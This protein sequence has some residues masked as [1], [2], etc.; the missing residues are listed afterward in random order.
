MNDTLHRQWHMLR[1]LPRAPRKIA[2]AQIEASLC[3][4]GYEID[5]RSIQRDLVNLSAMF[6]IECDNRSRPYGW[7]WSREASPFDLPCMDVHAALAFR[8]AAE[9]LEHLLPASTRSHLE[10]YFRQACTILAQVKGALADWPENVRAINTGPK[11]LPPVVDAVLLETVHHALMEQRR[12]TVEYTR[13]GHDTPRTYDLSPLGLVYRDSVA[14]LVA[15]ANGHD[16]PLQYA[17]HR[18]RSAT[19]TDAPRVV[20]PGFDLRAYIAGGAFDFILGAAPLQLR[21]LL[22]EPVTIKLSETPVSADQKLT[23]QADRRTLLEATVA[24][25]NQLR[26]WLR[27]F[28]PYVEVLEPASL[29]AQMAADA[30]ALAA[31]YARPTG[32]A[33]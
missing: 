29:R 23:P 8:V 26:A 32:G 11:L 21:A 9:H 16:D 12:L 27:S 5:R 13:R 30:Q 4:R 19:L 25:T 2:T 24:D 22:E 17:L 6:P 33:G 18:V 31:R 7:S 1:M 28:G 15:T 10:P 14:F 3:E 20:P